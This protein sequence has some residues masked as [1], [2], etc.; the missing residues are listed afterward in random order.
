MDMITGGIRGYISSGGNPWGAAAGAGMQ[1]LGVTDDNTMTGM[2]DLLKNKRTG[3]TNYNQ[4]TTKYIAPNTGAFATGG[5]TSRGGGRVATLPSANKQMFTGGGRMIGMPAPSNITQPAG[6]GLFRNVAP[7]M[8][9]T[10]A[11][12]LIQPGGFRGF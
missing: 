6:G 11:A 10:P 1:A 4:D 12:K 7:Q 2:G 8:T 3:D 9:G 5:S